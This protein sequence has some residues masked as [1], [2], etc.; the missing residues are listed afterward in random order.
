MKLQAFNIGNKNGEIHKVNGK[1][2][3]RYLST[4]R[5]YNTLKELIETERRLD[6]EQSTKPK[7]KRTRRTK[8]QTKTQVLEQ[9]T[10][11]DS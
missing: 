10:S 3:F 5:T 9:T 6:G 8:R 1:Y 4:T 7:T 2:E 11:Q